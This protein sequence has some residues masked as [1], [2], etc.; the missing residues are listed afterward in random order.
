MTADRIPR[1]RLRIRLNNPCA[2]PSLDPDPNAVQICGM[3]AARVME[4]IKATIA[5]SKKETAK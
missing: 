4:L 1:C 2:N 5:A 3:H